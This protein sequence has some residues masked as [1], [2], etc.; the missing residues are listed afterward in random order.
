MVSGIRTNKKVMPFRALFPS[1]FE[2]A[3]KRDHTQHQKRKKN[4]KKKKLYQPQQVNM[5]SILIF[6]IS[7]KGYCTSL[8]FY[9]VA[10][11][12]MSK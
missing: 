5:L 10:V 1:D 4:R 2:N 9:F 3:N 7:L 11:S 12:F 8:M 6:K